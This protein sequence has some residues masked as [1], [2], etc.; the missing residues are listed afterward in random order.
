MEQMIRLTLNRRLWGIVAL[1][2]V[3]L[4]AVVITIGIMTRSRMIEERKTILKQDVDIA[5]GVV[6]YFKKQADDG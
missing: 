4:I 5:L 2:W 1:L 6:S 3:C